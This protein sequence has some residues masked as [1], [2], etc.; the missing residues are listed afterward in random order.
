MQDD[1]GQHSARIND[2]GVAET[3]VSRDALRDQPLQASLNDAKRYGF[4]VSQRL[5]C[6]PNDPILLRRRVRGRRH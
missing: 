5:S 4:I 6:N 1:L 3:G 2:Q